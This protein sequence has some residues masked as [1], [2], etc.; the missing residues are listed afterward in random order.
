[1]IQPTRRRFCGSLPSAV[2]SEFDL[3]L[4]TLLVSLKHVAGTS[5]PRTGPW[6]SSSAS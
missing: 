2:E 1:L 6:S 3:R 4:R 5:S